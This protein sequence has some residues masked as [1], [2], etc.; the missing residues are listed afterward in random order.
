MKL[1]VHKLIPVWSPLYGFNGETIIPKGIITPPKMLGT[2]SCHINLM[3]IVVKVL[4]TYNMFLGRPNM[5]MAKVIHS[6]YHLV[7]KFPIEVD[8]GEFQRNQILARKRYLAVIK[9]K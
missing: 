8:V 6:T 3:I 5:K 7:M 4:S 1:L 9:G 2:S